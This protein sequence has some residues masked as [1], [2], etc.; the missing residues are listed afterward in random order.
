MTA[1]DICRV[2]IATVSLFPMFGFCQKVDLPRGLWVNCDPASGK[3]AVVVGP[4]V[5]A[6]NGSRAWV[7]VVSVVAPIEGMC[8]NTT[9]LWVSRGHLHPNLPIFTQSPVYP[10][11]EGNGMQI[12]DW[13]PNGRLLLTEMWQWNTEPNDAPIPRSILVFES[14]KKVKHQ[15]DIYRLIDDQKGRD[16]E[17]QFDLIGF[18]PDGWV[19]LKVR[20]STFYDVDENEA[21]KPKHLKCQESTQWLAI[22][23]FTQARRSVPSDFHAARYSNR[24]R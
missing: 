14:Q 20:I 8:L 22:N 1:T 10:N 17:V 12:V 6:K 18:T 15:I 24:G 21:T 23:P 13:S 19:S 5:T 9:T 16:C 2:V 7:Q 4:A 3:N 11:L